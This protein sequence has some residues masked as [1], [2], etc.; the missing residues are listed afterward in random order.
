LIH[1]KKILD[2]I[3][4]NPQDVSIPYYDFPNNRHNRLSRESAAA[5][6]GPKDVHNF[7]SLPEPLEAD[8]ELLC[9]FVLSRSFQGQNLSASLPR[10]AMSRLEPFP[11]VALAELER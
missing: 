3:G 6:I 4:T 1:F 2:N 11:Q 7:A 5:G 8:R 10:S 9:S